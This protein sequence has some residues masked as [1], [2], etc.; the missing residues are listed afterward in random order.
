MAN[1]FSRSRCGV[2]I[3]SSLLVKLFVP[4]EGFRTQGKNGQSRSADPSVAPGLQNDTPLSRFRVAGCTGRGAV[5]TRPLQ[6]LLGSA[7]QRQR[8][9]R[10][11]AAAGNPDVDP[12]AA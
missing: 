12:Q 7:E 1:P 9:P 2:S 5:S 6:A 10:S 4:E 8:P 11:R 3:L